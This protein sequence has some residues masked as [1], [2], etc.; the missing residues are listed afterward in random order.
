MAY[1]AAV[2]AVLLTFLKSEIETLAS[3]WLFVIIGL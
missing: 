2:H 3:Y 1:R